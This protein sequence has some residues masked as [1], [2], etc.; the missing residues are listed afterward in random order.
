MRDVLAATPAL[1][2]LSPQFGQDQESA[3]S[4]PPSLH[5]QG[6]EVRRRRTVAEPLG[7]VDKG[8]A[9]SAEVD[10]R[11]G[12]LD[13]RAILHV[14]ANLETA[15]SFDLDDVFQSSLADDGVGT[16]PEGGA[17]VRHALVQD[18][19]EV[20]RGAGESL[21]ARTCTPE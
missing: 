12:V 11:L 7:I 8:P 6:P 10:A 16:D 21:D 14:A 17:E 4:P 2:H 20:G 18:V 15:D 5:D 9:V 13:D 1:T 19:L 3:I